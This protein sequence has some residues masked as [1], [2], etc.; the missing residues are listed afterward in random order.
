MDVRD[1]LWDLVRANRGWFQDQLNMAGPSLEEDS[2][3]EH[4]LLTGIL[5]LLDEAKT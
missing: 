3:E 1:R 4:A 5:A 2:P